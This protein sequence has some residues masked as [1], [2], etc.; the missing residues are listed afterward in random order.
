MSLRSFS[1]TIFL[2]LTSVAFAANTV[3]AGGSSRASDP[4]C[5][6]I[7]IPAV[8]ATSGAAVTLPVNI[9]DLTGSGAFSFDAH[10]TFD[11]AVLE[12][13]SPPLTLGPVGQSQML[14][15]NMPSAGRLDISL[16][17]AVPMTGSGVLFNLNF[18]VIGALG[19]SS[20]VNL[21]TDS[22]GTPC[23]DVT[24]GSV[25]VGAS[26]SGTVMYGNASGRPIPNAQVCLLST[27]PV[28]AG[29]D[30]TGH[31]MLPVSGLGPYVLGVTK[32]TGQNGIS[33]N[34]AAR[35][36]QHVAATAPFTNNNQKVAADATNNGGLSANDAAQ[37]ARLVAGLTPGGGSIPN[38][39]RF[40]KLPGP[41]FPVGS[42]PTTASCEPGSTNC[43]FIGILIGEV[44]GNWV[45]APLR[46]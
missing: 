16:F 5:I 23:Y 25:T 32:T 33:S 13:L 24:N 21:T 38:V 42:S 18:H 8:Q 9:G 20:A 44:T 39:W 19:T 12:P 29:T 26:I 15:I 22:S 35:I 17:S 7:S 46:K 36:A 27:P 30:Q 10:I 11:A 40:F 45:S 41:T 3:N 4:P 28:C 31:Y 37:V 2:A 43:D 6:P 34:D 14:T 1:R